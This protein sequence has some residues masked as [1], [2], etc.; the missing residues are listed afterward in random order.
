MTPLTIALIAAL[1]VLFCVCAALTAR[2]LIVCKKINGISDNIDR[3][4]E[5]GDAIDFSTADDCVARLQNSVSELEETVMLER[6]KTA[7]QTRKNADFVADISH[8]L[9]TPLAGLRLYCE[10]ERES[11]PTAYTEKQLGLIEKMENLIYGLLRLEKIRSDAYSMEFRHNSLGDIVAALTE[12]F[13]HLFPDRQIVIKGNA[14]IRCDRV[15]LSEAIGNI[16]KNACEH[17]ETNGKITIEIENHE[18]SVSL[19]VEDDGGGIPDAELPKLFERFYRS[20]AVSS[21]GTGIGLAI[22]RVIA[23]KHHATVQAENGRHGLKVTLCFPVI[24]ASMKI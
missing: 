6:S 21:E 8:Q 3:F 13:R 22:T 5:S 19:I 16:I 24:D 11:Q 23:E 18:K 4:K 17:T 20:S 2:L 14:V 12:E 1:C 10:M 15:W 9:K 7:T